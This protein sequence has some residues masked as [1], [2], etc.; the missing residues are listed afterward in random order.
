MEPVLDEEPLD[1]GTA[2]ERVL[3]NWRDE[4]SLAWGPVLFSG[5]PQTIIQATSASFEVYRSQAQSITR[6]GSASIDAGKVDIRTLRALADQAGGTSDVTLRLTREAALRPHI[7]LPKAN[8]KAL[9]GALA[10]EIERI[11]PIPPVELYYDYG[12]IG[13]KGPLLDLELRLVKRLVLDNEVAACRAAGLA[14]A[15][16]DFDGDSR[17]VDASAFPIDRRAHLRLI[18][19]RYRRLALIALAAGL[20][21]AAIAGAYVRQSDKLEAAVEANADAGQHAARVEKLQ[22]TLTS[23]AND[24][25][26]AATQKRSPLLIAILA[27]LSQI[28]PDGT[29]VSELTFDGKS[30]RIVGSS[31]AA[32][33]LIGLIDR[34]PRFRGAHFEAPLVHDQ[35]NGTDRFDLSFALRGH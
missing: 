33:D 24:L 8:P 26:Y 17:S 9:R 21:M 11:S 2:I 7:T 12:V 3:A 34:A 30:V 18:F 25:S 5:A 23:A 28:L 35:A 14:V 31:S 22:H 1:L 15:R 4:L 19:R 13:P 16:I 6:V 29:Y 20:F 27:D 10:Y 32:A